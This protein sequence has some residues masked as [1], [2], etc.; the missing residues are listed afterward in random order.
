METD[1]P[2]ATNGDEVDK[3][4]D[5]NESKGLVIDDDQGA[6]A[7]T[8]ND[9]EMLEDPL[10]DAPPESAPPAAAP[11]PT[12][13]VTAQNSVK[14]PIQAPASDDKDKD[15]A[16]RSIWV[17]GLTSATKAADLKVR[18]ST[19]SVLLCRSSV[20]AG[21]DAARSLLHS[22]AGVMHAIRQSRTRKNI[23]VE[24]AVNVSLLR[25]RDDGRQRFGR[26]GGCRHAQNA[27]QVTDD[28]RGEGRDVDYA[29]CWMSVCRAASHG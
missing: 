5:L 17:R 2:P 14:T 3:V 8:A 15:I 23:H 26:E 20:G 9:E 6:A 18:N 28:L 12:V 10:V 1:A 11:K 4:D 19:F 24:E 13:T 27:D 21:L 7:A 22:F 29:T 25:I 16:S